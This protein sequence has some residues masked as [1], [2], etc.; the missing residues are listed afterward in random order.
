MKITNQHLNNYSNYNIYSIQHV[1]NKGCI[2][3]EN[4]FRDSLYRN[5]KKS[6]GTRQVSGQ[7]REKDFHKIIK[8][9]KHSRD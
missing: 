3:G 1:N 4:S 2:Q 5:T 7:Q 9:L 8:Q 6:R